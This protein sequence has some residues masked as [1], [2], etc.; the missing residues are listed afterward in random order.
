MKSTNI[1]NLKKYSSYG[2]FSESIDTRA[3]G[4]VT[5]M[6]KITI[7]HKPISLNTNLHAVAVTLSLHKTMTL[8]SIY[9]YM[10]IAIY[11]AEMN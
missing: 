2:I 8:F 4:G 3:S 1:I 11:L 5:I 9:I 6:I 10:L 7:S